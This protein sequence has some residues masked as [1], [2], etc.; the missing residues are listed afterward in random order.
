MC[1]CHALKPFQRLRLYEYLEAV[2]WFNAVANDEGKREFSDMGILAV[3][4]RGG[5]KI[6]APGA[7][8]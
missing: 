6:P 4:M 7:K 8:P 2:V 3:G 1:S 5:A